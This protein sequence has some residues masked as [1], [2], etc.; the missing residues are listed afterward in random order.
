MKYIEFKKNR[1]FDEVLED[2]FKFIKYNFISLLKS[3]W[4]L[5]MIYI[6]IYVLILF[7]YTYTTF[8]IYSNLFQNIGKNIWLEDNNPS[9]Q[10]WQIVFIF[11][12][13]YFSFRIYASIYGYIYSYIKNKGIID[14]DDILEV[15]NHKFWGYIGL[16][17]VIGIMLILGF[18]FLLIPG[19][20]L[21]VPI[22]LMIPAYFMDA[23]TL[24]EAIDKGFRY[25]KHHW[26][27]SFG[28]LLVTFFVLFFINYLF[29]IPTVI[30]TIIKA[31]TLL[32]DSD[33]TALGEITRDPIL[34]FL[35]FL[36]Q[37]LKYLLT[38]IQLVILAVLYY[39]LKEKQTAEGS[40]EKLSQFKTNRED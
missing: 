19:F 20:W 27:Y 37:L 40:L 2:G 6:V 11:Y 35:T 26:W 1:K 7:A 22:S 31:T 8:G 25:F 13:A 5:N 12:S 29:T 9:T 33:P 15:M 14:E 10:I 24:S 38:I 23:Q 34:I 32:K 3:I 17:L 16:F 28:V 30:Y 36:S 18:L 39:T 21:L 4:K